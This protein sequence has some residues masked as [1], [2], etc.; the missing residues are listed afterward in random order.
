M[1]L[2]SMICIG[3]VLWIFSLAVRLAWEIVKLI[4]ELI[5]SSKLWFILLPIAILIILIL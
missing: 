5:F 4:L 1:I 3:A 2:L